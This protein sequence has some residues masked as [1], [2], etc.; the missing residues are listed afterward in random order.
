MNQ[1]IQATENGIDDSN[2]II[3]G[4]TSNKIDSNRMLPKEVQDYDLE[5]VHVAD[6]SV[7]SYVDNDGQIYTIEDIP[8]LEQDYVRPLSSRIFFSGAEDMIINKFVQ[9][10]GEGKWFILENFLPN[11]TRHQIRER[12]MNYL[13]PNL[14]H[15]PFTKEDDELIIKLV[16][17]Y[18]HSWKTIASFFPTHSR[19]EIKCRW[20]SRLSHRMNSHNRKFGKD[21]I[22]KKR[23]NTSLI[24]DEIKQVEFANPLT[25]QV[26]TDNTQKTHKLE[27][28]TEQSFCPLPGVQT[29]LDSI[30]LELNDIGIACDSRNNDKPSTKPPPLTELSSV[31]SFRNGNDTRNCIRQ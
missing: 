16:A 21:K 25:P 18:G 8:S 6:E 5:N 13:S 12:Y 11:R 28:S 4:T 2:Q 20:N 1:S 14:K 24:K 23:K 10:Y 9:K 27:S 26:D 29:F 15:T 22:G 30:G 31:N 3:E 19:N 17:E 7:A